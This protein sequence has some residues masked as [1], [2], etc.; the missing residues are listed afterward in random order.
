MKTKYLLKLVA[1]NLA[2]T[3]VF[4]AALPSPSP[5]QA[6]SKVADMHKNML[7]SMSSYKL[8]ARIND[9]EKHG[10]ILD[11]LKQI[12]DGALRQGQI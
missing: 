7:A 2:L 3:T 11:L 9:H 4:A 6:T 1:L 12:E 10:K 5:S 8:I